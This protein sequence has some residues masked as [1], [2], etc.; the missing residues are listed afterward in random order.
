MITALAFLLLYVAVPFA[1]FWFAIRC[2]HGRKRTVGIAVLITYAAIFMI[3]G[4]MLSAPA[5]PGRTGA[6]TPTLSR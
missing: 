3:A 5:S 6:P 4:P 2:Q 1:L